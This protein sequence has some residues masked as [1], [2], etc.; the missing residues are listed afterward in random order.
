M[1]IICIS[2]QVVTASIGTD[3]FQESDALGMSRPVTK[4]NFQT[5]VANEIPEIGRP[6]LQLQSTRR[7]RHRVTVLR[8]RHHLSTDF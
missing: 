2:G 5:R 3:A 4:W 1:P 7:L 8:N 6:T